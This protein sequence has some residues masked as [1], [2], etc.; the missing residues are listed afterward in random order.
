MKVKQSLEEEKRRNTD[1]DNEE[2]MQKKKFQLVVDALQNRKNNVT[3]LHKKVNE[4]AS[5]EI[6]KAEAVHLQLQK[7][8][9]TLKIALGNTKGEIKSGQETMQF[10]QSKAIAE[11][12]EL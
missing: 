10:E 6:S 5:L 12:A 7:D 4:T 2:E 3:A 11:Q 9:V 1:L 8:A